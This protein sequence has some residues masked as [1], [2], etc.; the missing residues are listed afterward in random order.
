MT[1]KKTFLVT[2][3]AGFIPSH[4]IDKLLSLEYQ[5]IGLDDL[6]IGSKETMASFINHKQFRFVKGDV[7]DDK[8][9]KK[10]VSEVNYIYHG[11][12]RG[13][14]VSTADPIRDL[15]VN[16]ESTLKLL[17]LAQKRK[18]NF[19]IYPSSASVY[20]NPK[21]LPENEEDNPLPLSPYGVAKLASERYCLVYHHLYN[22]PVVCLRYFNNYGPRQRKDSVYGGVI[23]IFFEQAMKGQNLTVYGNGKQTRDFIFVEDTVRATVACIDN[24]KVIGE[25]INIGAGKETSI[26][27]LAEKIIKISEKKVGIKHVNKRLIDNIERRKADI[28][29]AKRLLSFFPKTDLVKGLKRTFSWLQKNQ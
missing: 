10:L 18:I 7:C 13:V 6:S 5:V 25:V 26:N 24:Q 12:I 2:G 1:K 20:G 15:R 23:S 28:S 17:D 16:T 11:A 29:K 21:H 9:L 3:S 27:K 19:F 4:L 14:N 22:L 8:L